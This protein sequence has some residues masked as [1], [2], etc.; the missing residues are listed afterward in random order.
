MESHHLCKPFLTFFFGTTTEVR[1]GVS[2]TRGAG[3]GL[4][5]TIDFIGQNA[6]RRARELKPASAGYSMVRCIGQ[7]KKMR[8]MGGFRRFFCP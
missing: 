5:K 1:I 7:E 2:L 3:G 6:C 8:R 4:H